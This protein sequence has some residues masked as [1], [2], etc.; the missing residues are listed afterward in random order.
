MNIFQWPCNCWEYPNSV[1]TKGTEMSLFMQETLPQRR[2]CKHI[3]LKCVSLPSLML[4]VI[5]R[6]QQVGHIPI[7]Q[8]SRRLPYF[9]SHSCCSGILKCLFLLQR[10]TCQ[11]KFFGHWCIITSVTGHPGLA[12]SSFPLRVQ[13]SW[14]LTYSLILKTFPAPS[15]I[16]TTTTNAFIY[17][18]QTKTCRSYKQVQA[19]NQLFLAS[20]LQ[21]ALIPSLD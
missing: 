7:V 9:T 8:T 12:E 2:H 15:I 17:T 21:T 14:I 4:L 18:S 16:T 10:V 19:K 3:S 13:I 11:Q 20:N 1:I 5:S 6:H